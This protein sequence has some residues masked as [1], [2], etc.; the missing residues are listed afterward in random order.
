MDLNNVEDRPNTNEMVLFIAKRFLVRACICIRGAIFE[1]SALEV[2]TS[3]LFV[4][5]VRAHID[6]SSEVG[7]SVKEP[8]CTAKIKSNLHTFNSLQVSTLD[9]T[10]LSLQ[11]PSPPSPMVHLYQPAPTPQ[12][13]Q[14]NI[15]NTRVKSFTYAPSPGMKRVFQR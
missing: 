14:R 6:F 3:P 13:V 11:H 9:E 15:R 2:I 7:D 12:R 1:S 4:F 10:S 5:S 8:R